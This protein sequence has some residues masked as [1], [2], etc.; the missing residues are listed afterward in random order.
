MHGVSWI[1]RGFVIS[2][3]VL[4]EYQ[5]ADESSRIVR[6]KFAFQWCES[7]GIPWW[8]NS[9]ELEKTPQPSH[10]GPQGTAS[11]DCST[12]TTDFEC[13]Q[14]LQKSPLVYKQIGMCLN[15]TCVKFWTAD[16]EE[17]QKFEYREE[18]LKLLPHTFGNLPRVRPT[19]AGR[20]I[21]RCHGWH[22]DKCGRLSSRSPCFFHPVIFD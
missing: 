9:Q 17:P 2:K 19:I 14:C 16:G 3:C 18:F 4:A 20:P 11:S 10:C 5:P 7:Q 8:L 12:E 13:Q 21:H 22:C 1:I 6:W 15:P